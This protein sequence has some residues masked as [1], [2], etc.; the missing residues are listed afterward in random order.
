MQFNAL[1]IT[2]VFLLLVNIV[3]V[4]ANI[5][6]PRFTDK[7][8]V[9]IVSVEAIVDETEIYLPN[10]VSSVISVI[11]DIL[12]AGDNFKSNLKCFEALEDQSLVPL[13]CQMQLRETAEKILEESISDR[14][15]KI[16]ALEKIEDYDEAELVE[17]LTSPG[18]LGFVSTFYTNIFFNF[19]A[20]ENIAKNE[21]APDMRAALVRAAVGLVN[22]QYSYI[23][24]FETALQLIADHD[25]NNEEKEIIFRVAL[26]NSGQRPDLISPKATILI[27]ERELILSRVS[28]EDLSDIEQRSEAEFSVVPAGMASTLFFIYNKKLNTVETNAFTQKVFSENP[29]ISATLKIEGSRSKI[30]TRRNIEPFSDSLELRY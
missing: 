2:N 21:I 27:G 24:A 28:Q 13:S 12:P 25:Q 23:P 10:S 20:V 8:S 26:L 1:L 11:I 4:F 5:Y 6:L 17:I 30:E 7:P 3:T 22:Q 14:E 18:K 29:S 15:Q 9:D 19:V 16:A